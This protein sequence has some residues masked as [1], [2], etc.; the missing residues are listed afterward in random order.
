MSV[1]ISPFSLGATLYMPA[2]R[3]DLSSIIIDKKI[4]D[5]RS[6]V[7]C[8]E[9]AL[10]ECDIPDAYRNLTNLA[11][12]IIERNP[13]ER[14]LLFIRPRSLEMAEHL[15]RN[16]DLSGFSGF[17]L[18]KFEL[19]A[20]EAWWSILE[21]TH[22]YMMPT[23]ETKEVFDSIEMLALA[24][25]L[26]V[27]PSKDRI[28]ALRIGGND[29]MST[30]SMRR[31]R[32]LTIYD[33]PIGFVIKMLV[34]IFGSRGFALTAPVCELI[35]NQAIMEKEL[36]LDVAHGLVGKTAIHPSQ[37]SVIERAFMATND[38]VSDALN[39]INSS[40]AVFS[41]QGAMCEPATHRHW[42]LGVLERSATFGVSSQLASVAPCDEAKRH[43]V[44][45]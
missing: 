22:L 2:N 12:D 43:H 29:L 18:P 26:E 33:G 21:N 17:V 39:I 24:K 7:I 36:E 32:K 31:S 44:K 30:L 34:S 3:P 19:C 15:V 35:N 1:K 4:R 9:D 16:F 20:L 25:A 40:K 11:Q 27:H 5:L 6:L 23:L 8:F 14:P 38:D 37:I 10:N 42:A 41:S 13:S 45:S 28:L